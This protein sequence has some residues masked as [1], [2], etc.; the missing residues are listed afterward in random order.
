MKLTSRVQ[1]A[2]LAVTLM[3]AASAFAHAQELF[4]LQAEK[5]T[6]TITPGNIAQFT[7]LVKN[8]AFGD[9]DLRMVRLVNDLP[10]TGWSSSMCTSTTCYTTDVSTTGV[11]TIP[12]GQSGSTTVDVSVIGHPESQGTAHVKIQY[13]LSDGTEAQ[14]LEFTVAVDG[15]ISSVPQNPVVAVES[16]F[17]NPTSATTYYSYALPTAGTTT[18]EVSSISGKRVMT[19]VSE[20]QEAG[21][22]T[23]NLDLSS[24]PNG[25]Y[26]VTLLG[27][28]VRNSKLV[29]VAR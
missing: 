2:M 23:L 16:L 28:G 1:Q 18:V 21:N 22:H 7:I 13:E 4:T 27:N 17:P 29:T 10:D 12:A 14:A 5:L 8:N 3:I 20:F 6:A 26:V 15:S 9:L 24:L 11:F 25:V 19:P